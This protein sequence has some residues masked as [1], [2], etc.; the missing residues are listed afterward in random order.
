MSYFTA[1]RYFYASAVFAVIGC[2]GADMAMGWVNP[3][4]GLGW[5]GSRP[6]KKV[7]VDPFAALRDGASS[8][9]SSA[10]SSVTSGREELA[11][12]KALRVPAKHSTPLCFWQESAADFP[13]LS[14]VARRILCISASSAQSERDFSAVGHT[15]TDTRSRLA[16]AKV[17]ATEIIRWGIRASVFCLDS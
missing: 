6:A 13:L 10:T 9:A 1:R 17:E 16:P 4:V 15:L 3:W 8:S 7:K 12:Y 14:A 2:V 5:V 11:R